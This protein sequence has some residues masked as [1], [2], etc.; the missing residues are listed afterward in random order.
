M[1][2]SN[3]DNSEENSRFEL[4]RALYAHRMSPQELK[5]LRKGAA[6]AATATEALRS[7]SLETTDEPLSVFVPY[8]GEE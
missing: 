1:G 3:A 2:D 7:V 5:E 6:E 4:V 8:R